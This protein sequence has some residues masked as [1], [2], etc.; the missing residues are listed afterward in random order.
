MSHRTNSKYNILHGATKESKSTTHDPMVAFEYKECPPQI[1]PKEFPRSKIK[2]IGV[3]ITEHL[4]VMES[5]R[6]S[7][8]TM[9][10]E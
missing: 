1:I 10:S 5:E 8:T 7:K 4:K 2:S 6:V 9:L 3:T